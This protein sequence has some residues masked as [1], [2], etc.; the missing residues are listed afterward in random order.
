MLAALQASEWIQLASAV[1]TAAAVLIALGAS[2]IT[3]ANE[4]RRT[5]PIVVAHEAHARRFREGREDG[6]AVGAYVTSEGGGSAFN[7]RFGVE[8]KGVRWGFRLNSED[9]AS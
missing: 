7:V 4:R 2:R 1:V 3:R 9:P 8:L 5:Q 6:W